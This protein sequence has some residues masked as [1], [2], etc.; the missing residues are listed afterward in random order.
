[1]IKSYLTYQKQLFKVNDWISEKKKKNIDMGVPQGSVL[2][3]LLFVIYINN[4]T[5]CSKFDVTL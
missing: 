3:P 5:L 2:G 1:M 4:L